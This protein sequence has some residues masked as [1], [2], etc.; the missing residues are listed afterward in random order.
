MSPSERTQAAGGEIDDD[1]VEKKPS[2]PIETFILLCTAGA[3]ILSI[4][5]ASKELSFYVNPK[6]KQLTSEYKKKPVQLFQEEYETDAAAERSGGAG[7]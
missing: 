4:V 2:H 1:I 5:L 6:V 3:L 7:G